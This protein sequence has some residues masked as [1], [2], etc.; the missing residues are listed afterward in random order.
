MK[1]LGIAVL[2]TAGVAATLAAQEAEDGGGA[3][4]YYDFG[5][6]N[7]L[8]ALT[9]IDQFQSAMRA[10]SAEIDGIESAARAQK[11]KIDTLWVESQDLVN[12]LKEDV[13]NLTDLW[14]RDQEGGGFQTKNDFDT[15][16]KDTYLPDAKEFVHSSDLSSYTKKADLSKYARYSDLSDYAKKTEIG[17]V[18]S[19]LETAIG[20]LKEYDTMKGKVDKNTERI[21]ALEKG[22]SSGD[23]GGVIG[24]GAY[25]AACKDSLKAIAGYFGDGQFAVE[26]GSATNGCVTVTTSTTLLDGILNKLPI[27]FYGSSFAVG[28]NA[29]VQIFEDGNLDAPLFGVA[30]FWAGDGLAATSAS[31]EALVSTKKK[32]EVCVKNPDGTTLQPLGDLIDGKKPDDKTT[33]VANVAAVDENGHLRVMPVG[34]ISLGVDGSTIVRERK[35]ASDENS[36]VVMKAMIANMVDGTTIKAVGEGAGAKAAVQVGELC[37]GTTIAQ[38]AKGR[39]SVVGGGGSALK[40]VGTDGDDVVV[41]SG[42]TTNTVTF[43]SASDSNVKVNVEKSGSTGV[44]VTIGVYYK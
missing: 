40:F 25:G 42:S 23:G 1:R 30:D 12:G 10:K 29:P 6:G 28:K 17:D 36:D 22:A 33:S 2:I 34:S 35:D 43:A 32:L 7:G 44:K 4:G 9:S 20:A 21:T 24:G 26:D 39:L 41:G 14:N 37:D 27:C 5:D 38:D 31:D 16:I 11:E 15:W 13:G 3:Y 19:T 18:K 8:T